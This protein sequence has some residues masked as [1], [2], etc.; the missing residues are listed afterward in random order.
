M[1]GRAVA[2][3][4]EA[5][6]AGVRGWPCLIPEGA[7]HIVSD[8]TGPIERSMETLPM[9]AVTHVP[10]AE[11]YRIGRA[12]RFVGFVLDQEQ[13]DRRSGE[14]AH[15]LLSERARAH[16]A[17]GQSYT[18][19]QLADDF[20]VA[21][22]HRFST[23]AGYIR[24]RIL[25]YA[26]ANVPVRRADENVADLGPSAVEARRRSL[27]GYSHPEVEDL[28]QA[29]V[30]AVTAFHIQGPLYDDLERSSWTQ[31]PTRIVRTG[32]AFTIVVDGQHWVPLSDNPDILARTE[33]MLVD[34]RT[35]TWTLCERAWILRR[36]GGAPLIQTM[37]LEWNTETGERTPMLADAVYAV[38]GT[39]ASRWECP[40]H[41]Q[42]RMMRVPLGF[43]ALLA[44]AKVTIEKA[45]TS[46]GEAD[47]FRV[48]LPKRYDVERI[49]DDINCRKN[50]R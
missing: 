24:G 17:S 18:A 50:L 41:E 15:R 23:E 44:H 11:S 34:A 10:I 28:T 21:F 43:M 20:L 29:L 19:E 38:T 25:T 2:S 39:T 42:D 26:Y 1:M 46:V 4:G 6:A 33:Y 22:G 32:S 47:R 16:A 40:A 37:G 8:W 13:Q 31:M 12:F 48:A 36:D 45:A 30:P 14:Q 35:S 3:S 9:L 27:H 7:V 5:Y 49:V